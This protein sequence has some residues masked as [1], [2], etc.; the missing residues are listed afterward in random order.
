MWVFTNTGFVSAV[1]TGK[2][3]MV[4]ARDRQSLTPLSTLAKT[5]I[6]KSPTHDYPY[7][8]FITNELFAEWLANMAKS[9]EYRNFKAEVADVR[10]YDFSKPLMKVWS[11]MHEVEDKEA[12][13]Q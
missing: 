8:V 11:V 10:G 7:R 9:V 6:K 13:I 1:S 12:R 5:E 3:L 2:G 4:R